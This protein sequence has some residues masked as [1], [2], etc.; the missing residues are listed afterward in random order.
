MSNSDP[1]QPHPPTP[2]KKLKKGTNIFFNKHAQNK[3]WI[4]KFT[5]RNKRNEVKR[6][7]ILSILG[8]MFCG[9]YLLTLLEN[10]N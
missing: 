5:L 2:Q 10:Y 4:T 3:S 9:K 7:G 6:L 8:N 1:L